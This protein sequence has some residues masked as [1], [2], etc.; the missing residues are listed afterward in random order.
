MPSLSLFKIPAAI[1]AHAKSLIVGGDE[2]VSPSRAEGPSEAPRP[3]A[4]AAWDLAAPDNSFWATMAGADRRLAELRRA[5][6]EAAAETMACEAGPDLGSGKTASLG[7]SRF[8]TA[9][10]IIKDA[11]DTTK[12]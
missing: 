12:P 11:L 6:E 5:I 9:N 2:D 8:E 1:L 3:N 7:E 4:G 10:R